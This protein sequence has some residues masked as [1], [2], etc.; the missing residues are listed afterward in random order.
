[1]RLNRNFE[2]SPRQIVCRRLGTFKPVPDR[3]TFAA[4]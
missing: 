3:V 4:H 2:L 1:L